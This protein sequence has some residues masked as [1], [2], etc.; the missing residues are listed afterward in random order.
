MNASLS[1]LLL[2]S[3]IFTA[4]CAPPN[5]ATVQ[6][7]TLVFDAATASLSDNGTITYAATDIDDDATVLIQDLAA[8]DGC[9]EDN[10]VSLIISDNSGGTWIASSVCVVIDA[11][12]TAPG[13]RFAG[14]YEATLIA[15]D[16]NDDDT[17]TDGFFDTQVN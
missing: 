6:G 16:G 4:A 15:A 2:L 11:F 10:D 8:D 5:R 3:F 9:V 7:E 12:P 13:Q 14:T 1:G 17:L